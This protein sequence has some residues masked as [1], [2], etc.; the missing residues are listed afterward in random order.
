[1]NGNT[2]VLLVFVVPPDTTN[3]R[4]QQ[5]RVG[6]SL[7][8]DSP[9]PSIK[10][11]RHAWCIELEKQEITCVGQLRGWLARPHDDEREKFAPYLADFDSRNFNS[12]YNEQIRGIAQYA[13]TMLVKPDQPS[14]DK[15]DFIS[16]V[17]ENKRLMEE[18]ASLKSQIDAAA[19]QSGA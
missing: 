16:L 2:E 1:M 19:A 4:K 13:L 7:N 14:P 6:K 15:E 17:N 9:I 12:K 5:I 3:F 10:R 8:D 18:N 11:M